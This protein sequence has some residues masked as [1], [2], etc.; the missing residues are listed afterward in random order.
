M[1]RLRL[2]LCGVLVIGLLALPAVSQSPA[3]QTR[4]KSPDAPRLTPVAET[5]LLM[6]G[7]TQANFQG[8]EKILKGDQIDSDSW[9]FARGQALLIAESGNL[10]MMRP[11]RNGGQDAW[12]KG[13]SE[14]R[15]SSAQLAK[16]V[17]KRDVEESRAG[18]QRLA[19]TCNNCH[20]TFRVPTKIKAFAEPKP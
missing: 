11:P 12:M 2:L 3:T 14:L 17:A 16:I 15:N 4:P 8:L 5:K 9:T 6:E 18:L 1:P 7:L 20:Q 13:A 19:T 10:L